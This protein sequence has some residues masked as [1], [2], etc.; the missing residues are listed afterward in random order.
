MHAQKNKDDDDETLF[1]QKEMTDYVECIYSKRFT[2]NYIMAISRWLSSSNRIILI[3][4]LF[5][6]VPDSV[7]LHTNGY[8]YMH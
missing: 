4:F 8:T 5:I 7:V 3:M 6:V 2:Q 1:V